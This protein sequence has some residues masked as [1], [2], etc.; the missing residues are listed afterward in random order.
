M[1]STELAL[2]GTGFAA[3]VLSLIV[4]QLLMGGLEFKAPAPEVTAAPTPGPVP[5][6]KRSAKSGTPIEYAKWGMSAAELEQIGAGTITRISPDSLFP[7][8]H[9][10]GGSRGTTLDVKA[11]VLLKSSYATN[12]IFYDAI[13]YF[14]SIQLFN[15]TLVPRS[16]EDGIFENLVALTPR[17]LHPVLFL[18][19]SFP[20]L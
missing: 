3:G 17:S 14:N 18:P 12:G 15:A 5:E 19:R 10:I 9:R 13:Y 2:R 4:V 7:D 8:D 1:N 6:A 11:E 20:R 16:I